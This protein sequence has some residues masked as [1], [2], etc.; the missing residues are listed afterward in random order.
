MAIG[1][2]LSALPGIGSA[3]GGI[4]GLF[5]KQKN[6][7][8]AAN[9]YL[10]KIPGA[11]QP[12]YQPY[13]QAGKGALGN[14]QNMYGE[15]T[16]NPGELFSRLGAGYQASPG[17]QFALKQALAAGGNAAAAG[18]MLGTPQHRDNNMETAQG[19]ASKDFE[20]YINHVLGLYGQ[21]REGLEELNKLGYGANTGYGNVLGSVLGQQAQNA[22]TGQTGLNQANQANWSNIFGGLG[23]AGQ[24]Y[25]DYNQ[26]QANAALLSRLIGD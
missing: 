12:Y 23:A 3:I 8:D 2:A 11:M 4:A 25:N 5:H 26:Q 17:Y 22:F 20:N 15:L 18:G 1:A 7:A 13:M 9:K 16:G 10:D 24:G 21:G 19:L 14:L 6:P